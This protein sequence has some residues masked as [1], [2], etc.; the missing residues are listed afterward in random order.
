MADEW[1]K[2]VLSAGNRVPFCTF[3]CYGFGEWRTSFLCPRGNNSDSAHTLAGKLKQNRGNDEF[4]LRTLQF[5]SKMQYFFLANSFSY[6]FFSHSCLSCLHT[7]ANFAR[8]SQT[9]ARVAK[10]VY[11][12]VLRPD[13]LDLGSTQE[14][15]Y[16]NVCF[17]DIFFIF[18][19][20]FF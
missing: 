1:G 9:S 11:F 6:M 10:K 14:F 17:P 7:L 3:S 4:E 8:A 2:T 16:N 5:R 15:C 12:I 18:F 19:S 20:I 13:N